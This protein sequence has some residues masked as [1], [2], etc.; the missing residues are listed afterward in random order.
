MNSDRRTKSEIT[1]ALTQPE[2]M[3]LIQALMN[4]HF[5]TFNEDHPMTT[6]QDVQVLKEKLTEIFSQSGMNNVEVSLLGKIIN[7]K[8]MNNNLVFKIS[9]GE[10]DFIVKFGQN[11]AAVNVA[12]EQLSKNRKPKWLVDTYVETNREK[13]ETDINPPPTFNVN[14]AETFSIIESC[15]PFDRKVEQ[16]HTDTTEDKSN[17]ITQVAMKTAGNLAEIFRTMRENN[18]IWTDLKPGNLLMRQDGSLVIADTKAFR[19][20]DQLLTRPK[21]DIDYDGQTSPSYVSRNTG[22]ECNPDQA[23]AAWDVEYRYQMAVILYKIA[24]NVNKLTDDKFDF[25]SF[26]YFKT[27]VGERLQSIIEN[28]SDPDPSKSMH[29]EDAAVLLANIKEDRVYKAYEKFINEGH[30]QELAALTDSRG[31]IDTLSKDSRIDNKKS[32][33][34]LLEQLNNLSNKIPKHRKQEFKLLLT[35]ANRE[36]QIYLQRDLN[37]FKAGKIES[38]LNALLQNKTQ[39]SELDREQR[40]KIETSMTEIIRTLTEISTLT[41]GEEKTKLYELHASTLSELNQLRAIDTPLVLPEQESTTVTLDEESRQVLNQ[42]FGAD[43][44][45]M[46]DLIREISPTDLAYMREMLEDTSQYQSSGEV[47]AGFPPNLRDAFNLLL[48]IDNA[49]KS[50][51]QT[52]L[53]KSTFGN[54]E[55]ERAWRDAI[56]ASGAELQKED[57]DNVFAKIRFIDSHISKEST[58]EDGINFTLFNRLEAYM[59]RGFDIPKIFETDPNNVQG[60]IDNLMQLDQQT[61]QHFDTLIDADPKMRAQLSRQNADELKLLQ[62]QMRTLRDEKDKP[63][64]DSVKKLTEK[65]DTHKYLNLLEKALTDPNAFSM[66]QDAI[67][68]TKNFRALKNAPTRLIIDFIKEHPEVADIFLKRRHISTIVGRNFRDDI[69][70]DEAF[71]ELEQ[72]PKLKGILITHGL[73]TAVRSERTA[74]ISSPYP[75]ELKSDSEISSYFMEQVSSLSNQVRSCDVLNAGEEYSARTDY[76]KSKPATEEAV[77]KKK[78]EKTERALEHAHKLIEDITSNTTLEKSTKKQLCAQIH[79]QV[80]QL[81]DLKGRLEVS[82]V[83]LRF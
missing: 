4:D 31:D 46:F 78:L 47:I 81:T 11:R 7:G 10:H 20:V 77:N 56:M 21:G 9:D 44:R 42:Q 23:L 51:I 80:E 74:Q 19:R 6:E 8:V 52:K 32:L 35:N 13:V 75:R 60:K 71:K 73:S 5:D 67:K 39:W 59:I 49:I 66:K 14:W 76:G 33:R 54:E 68:A 82:S 69:R 22:T 53:G 63:I 24:T 12:V 26:D 58:R 38:E 70:N 18:V 30:H 25:D 37:D 36:F 28:L 1:T 27:K 62:E 3:E 34:T 50:D 64:V 65:V 72:N 48:L 83:R 2:Q 79:E 15:I 40:L 16:L 43:I 55:I 41:E 17:Q 61:S 29:Y 57:L 45:R